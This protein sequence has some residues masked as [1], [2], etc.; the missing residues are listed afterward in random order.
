MSMSNKTKI[1]LVA[2]HG[3]TALYQGDQ[4]VWEGM[5]QSNPWIKGRLSYLQR[6]ISLKDLQQ[7][8]WML[9]PDPE[10]PGRINPRARIP[11]AVL[12]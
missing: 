6:T 11:K 7:Q 10:N 8:G 4:L 5:A 3:H 12:M 1:I 9:C 2:K